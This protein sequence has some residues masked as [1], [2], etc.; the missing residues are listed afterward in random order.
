MDL[1][2]ILNV[3]VKN[4]VGEIKFFLYVYYTSPSAAWDP[5]LYG[6]GSMDI[7]LVP[8]GTFWSPDIGKFL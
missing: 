7:I 6:D 1:F 3:D 5:S 4:G 8:A 2:Q